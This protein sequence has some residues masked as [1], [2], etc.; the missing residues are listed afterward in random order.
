MFWG[1]GWPRRGNESRRDGL[2]H[3]KKIRVSAKKYTTFPQRAA[4]ANWLDL[5]P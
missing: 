5:R 1:A 2:R 4:L 3:A